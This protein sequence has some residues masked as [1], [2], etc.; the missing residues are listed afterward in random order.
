[1][2]DGAY[3]IRVVA[4]DD[5]GNRATSTVSVLVQNN[6]AKFAT[7]DRVQ[8]TDRLSVRDA[9][10]GERLGVQRLGAQGTIIGGP[11]PVRLNTWW[12]ID[13]ETEPD[14]WSSDIY[15][16]RVGGGVGATATA[17]QNVASALTALEQSLLQILE[18]LM[19]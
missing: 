1:M 12:Q 13:W 2:P 6:G 7:G 9:P 8:T 18:L 14:G 4:R 15:L 3:S 5:A 17:L 16:Q 19:Q 11:V 10:A